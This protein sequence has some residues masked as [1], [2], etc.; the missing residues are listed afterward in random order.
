MFP[1]T[2]V[3]ALNLTAQQRG[4]DMA[5]TSRDTKERWL[6]RDEIKLILD[7]GSEDYD[8]GSDKTDVEEDD[9]TEWPQIPPWQALQGVPK[10]GRVTGRTNR[11]AHYHTPDVRSDEDDKI[12]PRPLASEGVTKWGEPTGGPS[13][14]VRKFI[15]D[16]PGKRQNVAPNTNKDSTPYSVSM[17]YVASV[18]TL[19]VEETN[20]YYHQYLDTLDD[21]PSPL[22]DVTESEMFVSGDYCS[23]GTWLM[24]QP[25]GL[26]FNNWTVPYTFL[27]HNNE[28][29]QVLSHYS[30]LHFSNNDRASDKNDPNYDRLWKQKY[31]WLLERCLLKIQ[32]VP[33]NAPTF[34]SITVKKL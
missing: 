12:T 9:L 22:L 3:F 13:K 21:W 25:G 30:V 7:I 27:W 15:G 14:G 26:L 11:G 19:L 34:Q 4:Q 17:L 20:R 32:G 6:R 8:E 24:R 23:N 31:F 10:W 33:F 18:T 16:T 28:T 2:L 29:W 5:F 1:F